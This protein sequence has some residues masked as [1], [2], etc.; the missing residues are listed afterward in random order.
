RQVALI[1]TDNFRIAAHEQLT[2]YGRILDV[3]VRSAANAQELRSLING[4]FDKK[5][6]LIDTAG[7]GPRDMRLAE[8][9]MTLKE[10]DMPVKSYLV[11]TATTQ[12]K[13]MQTIIKAFQIVKP[14][15]CIITKMDEAESKGAV[16]STVIEQQL[17]VAFITDG[18]QVP[19]DIHVPNA[20]RLIAQCIAELES[21]QDHAVTFGYE[22]WV[23][24]GYA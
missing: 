15:G 9:L 17:P 7:M 14:S 23:A 21:E 20:Q 11:M 2:T 12:Y 8:Q 3:P 18:Q 6:I 16:I 10:H 4:F 24:T 19:E 22:D 13:A 1:T 5:L